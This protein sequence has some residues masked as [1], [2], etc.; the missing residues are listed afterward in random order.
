MFD[1]I[2]T[3]LQGSSNK[4]SSNKSSNS[5]VRRKQEVSLQ[6]TNASPSKNDGMLNASFRNNT[7]KVANNSKEA[8]EKSSALNEKTHTKTQDLYYQYGSR[9]A[10]ILVDEQKAK[11]YVFRGNKIEGVVK[12]IYQEGD[13][14]GVYSTIELD[15]RIKICLWK[16]KK[17]R[18]F[19][20]Q[21]SFEDA[22][23][24]FCEQCEVSIPYPVFRSM[25]RYFFRDDYEN[26]LRKEKELKSVLYNTKGKLRETTTLTYDN[27]PFENGKYSRL[28]FIKDG[29]VFPFKGNSILGVAVI[30][31]D[32]ITGYEND[33][34]HY[35]SIFTIIT[36]SDVKSIVLSPKENQ[37]L[38][39][40][41][42]L[43]SAYEDFKQSCDA[44]LSFDEFKN[45]LKECYPSNYD[46][47]VRY[48]EQIGKFQ[49]E[50]GGEAKI[51]SIST[52]RYRD[53]ELHTDIYVIE[54]NGR[55]WIISHEA[56]VGTKIDGVCEILDTRHI[57]GRRGG[58]YEYEII[59][60]DG[61]QVRPKY[62][63][64]KSS[65]P[66]HYFLNSDIYEENS[67]LIFIREITSTKTKKGK[68]VSLKGGVGNTN[69]EKQAYEKRDEEKE[70]L[71][72]ASS[73]A[74][75]DSERTLSTSEALEA[76][77]KMFG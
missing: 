22:W 70:K 33:G 75:S 13:G 7:N 67:D 1:K 50:V 26:L 73:I 23:K 12:V 19:W 66:Y 49:K 32:Q 24:A 41:H 3:N 72:D 14:K 4:S 31:N 16:A 2:D 18:P 53:E 25:V 34:K 60:A 64:K 10:V 30:V 69:I 56:Q 45:F 6:G 76:L 55:K 37:K 48:E 17:N 35:S 58:V 20:P 15:E 65:Y 38:W 44:N 9:E 77:K 36:P 21:L 43:K 28:F 47:I 8:K 74:S 68:G 71:S 57:K 61:V 29:K 59:A 42:D 39:P 46:R 11:L 62:Y 27:K 54:P 52:S 5:E 63:P 51:V 40:Q